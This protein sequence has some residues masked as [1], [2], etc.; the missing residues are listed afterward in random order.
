MNKRELKEIRGLK[1]EE[2]E[3]RLDGLVESLLKARV[4]ISV[5]QEKNVRKAKMIRRDISQIKSIIR[6]KGD[7]EA[8]Q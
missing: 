1:V 5:G 7:K 4:D 6:E 3:K 8:K 2:L